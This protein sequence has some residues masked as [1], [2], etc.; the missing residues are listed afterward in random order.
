MEEKE[1][2]LEERFEALQ[3]I[4]HQALH[5]LSG[6]A[7]IIKS[8]EFLLDDYEQENESLHSILSLVEDLCTSNDFETFLAKRTKLLKAIARF[9]SRVQKRRETTDAPKTDSLNLTPPQDN[10]L[11]S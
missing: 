7:Q 8:F 1:E 4:H 6:A 3:K 11:L 2:T 10:M 9:R 5:E